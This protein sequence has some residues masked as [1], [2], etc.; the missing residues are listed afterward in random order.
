MACEFGQFKM[1]WIGLFQENYTVINL[2]E[3][4][5]MQQDAIQLNSEEG[6]GS[7]FQVNL[8]NWAES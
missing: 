5:G 4:F 1:A 8:K 7:T 3:Q 2:A 6:I